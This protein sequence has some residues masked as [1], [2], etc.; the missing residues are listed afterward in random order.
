M[1]TDKQTT[2]R[3]TIKEIENN[4]NLNLAIEVMAKQQHQRP[5]AGALP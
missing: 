4:G 2:V 1:S 5:Q 3:R